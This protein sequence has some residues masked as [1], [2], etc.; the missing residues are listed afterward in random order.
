MNCVCKLQVLRCFSQV[1][2]YQENLL[3]VQTSV[4]EW[5]NADQAQF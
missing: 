3:T 1:A 5:G 4:W 2:L